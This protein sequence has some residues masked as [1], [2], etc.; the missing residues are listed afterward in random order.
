MTSI[1]KE[2]EEFV[3]S[4]FCTLELNELY[5]T[6]KDLHEQLNLANIRRDISIYHI[7]IYN[8]YNKN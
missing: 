2:I 4:Q 1:E 6:Y 5:Y 3:I 8:R 7:S